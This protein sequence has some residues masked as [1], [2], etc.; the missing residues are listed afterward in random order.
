MLEECQVQLEV[1]LQV[2]KSYCYRYYRV[3]N[4]WF[5]RYS[6]DF[7]NLT[8]ATRSYVAGCNNLQ[9]VYCMGGGNPAGG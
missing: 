9:E 7:G 6:T 5:I 8:A 2:E 1:Y 4:N 3:H